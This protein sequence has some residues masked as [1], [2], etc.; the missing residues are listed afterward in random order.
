[1]PLNCGSLA[2]SDATTNGGNM[3]LVSNRLLPAAPALS[4]TT[5]SI[6]MKNLALGGT[7]VNLVVTLSMLGVTPRDYQN[8]MSVIHI[9]DH[10][11][12]VQGLS[13]S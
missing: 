4:D 3:F 10:H 9:L 5:P 13:L 6:V 12:S 7:F 8:A 1:V 2:A 11:L